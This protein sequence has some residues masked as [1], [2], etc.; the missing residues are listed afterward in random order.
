MAFP[1]KRIPLRSWRLGERKKI[2]TNRCCGRL[3][4]P[5]SH[6]VASGEEM[7]RR[8]CVNC[9]SSPGFDP[10]YM[11][12]ARRL[13]QALVE[14]G[15]ELIYGGADV[16]LMGEVANTVLQAGGVVR[17]IIPES[18]AQKVSHKGLTELRI[19]PSMHERKKLMFDLSDAFIAL[20]GGFGTLEEVAEVLTW[21][22]LGLHTKPCGL[23]NVN[24]YFDPFLSFLDGAVVEGFMKPEHRR[25]LL[26]ADDPFGLLDQMA[27]Y[28]APMI[29]KWVGIKTRAQ[30][31]GPGD[32]LQGA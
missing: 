11:S 6:D 21:A 3:T 23:I 10:C 13:G 7:M 1:N 18:F 27:A 17:G 9:G 19:V 16:G 12:M 24:G 30:P 20:P 5:Q 14:R 31:A 4:P 32:A 2:R 22:Q 26:V 28:K 8:L 15:C 25:M 29:E